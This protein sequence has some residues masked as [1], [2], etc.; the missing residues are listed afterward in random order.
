VLVTDFGL[1]RIEGDGVEG[2]GDGVAG[3][4]EAGDA[5][6]T[7]RRQRAIDGLPATPAQA[8][9][10]S[11]PLDAPL[12]LTGSVLGTV[13]YMAPEQAFG[14]GTNAATDQFSY[15]ATAYVALYGVRPFAGDD[16]QSYMTAVHERLGEPPKGSPV[17]TWI[18]RILA[19]GLSPEPQDRFPSMEAL[20]GEL[21]LDPAIA[22]R[23]RVMV[24]VF[25]VGMMLLVIAGVRAMKMQSRECAVDPQAL[26]GAW[27]D[28]AKQDVRA[29][30]VRA[31]PDEG[32][33][34]AARVVRVLDEVATSWLAMS[35]DVCEASRVRHEQTVE[36]HKLRDDCLDRR[37]TEMRALTAMFRTA[38]A[39]VVKRSL[40]AAYGLQRVAF[41]ADVQGLKASAGLPDDPAIRARVL[42][43]R[44]QLARARSLALAG[45]LTE[46]LSVGEGALAVARAVGHPSTVAE[47]LFLLGEVNG[48]L[49]DY[50]RAEP[51]LAEA[52]WTAMASGTDAITTQAA[53]LSAFIVGAKLRR[54]TEA[55]VWLA[56]ADAALRHLGGSE[57]LEAYVQ[58]Q[59]AAVVAEADWRPELCVDVDERIVTTYQRLYGVHPMTE[60]A[61]YGLGVD[62]TYLGEHRQACDLYEQARVMAETIGGPMYHEV[63]RSVYALADCR[64]A[65]GDYARGAEAL[66]RALAI[67]DH[68]ATPYWSAIALQVAV[69]AAL[70]QGDTARAV[71]EARRALALMSTMTSTKVLVP[72]VNVPAADALMAA[73]MNDEALAL[74]DKALAVE[75]ETGQLD[76]QKV[77]GWDALRCRGDALV[78]VGRGR[79]AVPLLERSLRLERRMYAGE[80]ARVRF[81][82]AR[83][84]VQ[85]DG[86]RARARALAGDARDELA[87]HAFLKYELGVVDRWIASAR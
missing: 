60:R 13:G 37:R 30:F 82:L 41:C 24:A 57:E 14:E 38:D 10:Y 81:A 87:Q 27:D 4:L 63:G 22:R 61:L 35:A 72:I 58:V 29:A 34:K 59:R 77:L 70:A 75:E 51:L 28:T 33:D 66:A 42:D 45:K 67:F 20:L 46:A 6:A 80:L 31:D 19:R 65:Q 53:A 86:D 36:V 68:N 52:T 73:G 49:G 64:V 74:C 83:A 43:A 5:S 56:A 54:A 3:D 18:H 76:P 39:E 50:V 25:I 55:R 85:S 1:A 12:T 69:R 2:D 48:N 44:S 40:D 47:A 7:H 84:L 32:A 17:P 9:G 21:D 78:H 26:A 79:E 62:H 8:D 71:S 16:L 15:C 23:K 11:T